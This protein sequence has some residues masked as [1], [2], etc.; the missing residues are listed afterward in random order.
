MALGVAGVLADMQWQ[1]FGVAVGSSCEFEALATAKSFS[2]GSE[3]IW[4]R[5]LTSW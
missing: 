5:W 2:I 1:P 4:P 3:P